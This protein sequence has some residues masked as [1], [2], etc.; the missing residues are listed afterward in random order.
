[1]G[2]VYL[3][4]DNRLN[5]NVALK[6]VHAAA[7]GGP[8]ASRLLKEARAASSLNHPN[9]AQIY[10]VNEA[11]DAG[12]IAME[13][14]D[15]ETLSGR[16]M[17]SPPL[18]PA[19]VINIGIEVAEA[20]EE[21]HNHG[22]IHR[23]IKPANIMITKKGR[24][25][26]LDF[27]VA[28]VDVLSSASTVRD[29]P[30]A[31]TGAVIGTVRYMSPEQARGQQVDSRSDLF[32]LGIVLYELATGRLPF[33][34]VSTFEIL[35]KIVRAD[36]PP[37]RVGLPSLEDI[38]GR[39]LQKQPDRRPDSATTVAAA[40]RACLIESDLRNS[41]AKK[42]AVPP[43]IVRKTTIVV[44]TLVVAALFFWAVR[45]PPPANIPNARQNLVIL[46][47]H[48]LN[49]ESRDQALSDG[50][51]ENVTARII[52][53]ASRQNIDVT[54]AA[55]VKSRHVVKIE[56]AR[57]E[58]GANLAVQGTA[59]KSGT[60]LRISWTLL[61]TSTG[62]TIRSDNF[63][64]DNHDPFLLQDRMLERLAALLNLR[65]SM[66]DFATPPKG[67]IAAVGAY[68]LYLQGRGY[69]QN[70]DKPENLEN[71]ITVFDEA[72]KMDPNYA[73]VHAGL[74][75]TYWRKYETTK[76]VKWM[77]SARGAC[78]HALALD[79]VPAEPHRCLGFVE[80]AVGHYDKA[81]LEFQ[82]AIAREPNDDVA[83]AGMA[84]AYDRMNDAQ[85]AEEAYSKAIR[86]RPNYWG[87]YSQF[88][89]YYFSKAR[90]G[91]AERMFL[92]VISLVPDSYRGYSNLGAMHF[93]QGKI[94]EAI[95]DYSKSMSLKPNYQAA[96]N[97]GT[98]YYYEGDYAKSAS[99][100]E[101][102]LA[103]NGTD[104]RVWGNLGSARHL[105][106]NFDGASRAFKEAIRMGE[107]K[108]QVNPN[109]A[110]LLA[111]LAGYYGPVGQTEKAEMLIRNALRLAPNNGEVLYR[112][113]ALYESDLHQRE[114]ALSFIEKTI[115]V[116]FSRKE[117]DRSPL[118]R[119][120][121]ND[122]RFKLLI[123]QT[124]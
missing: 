20:L 35:E 107:L 7:G 33:E 118:F 76:D 110:V 3:A 72:L 108:L 46:P 41:T 123:Q 55:D 17:H 38:I 109:D 88:G 85:K 51:M 122:P 27:G 11:G 4:W 120:L 39:C 24:I 90:Y 86:M 101:Q 64:L 52:D 119:E 112:A 71:A 5:R 74:G 95:K 114:K 16:M 14:V 115:R 100:V 93:L 113:A 87:G 25:K 40:L 89:A 66:D 68:E 58:L 37:M 45:R 54:A 22:V 111:Q 26:V 99:N 30:T 91:E 73:L 97:L 82:H 36:P 78:E 84:S 94:P 19:E 106:Q 43:E 13:Y 18:T 79:E 62:Q 8:Q 29:A 103:I 98:L 10:E 48:F 83:Y 121:R 57:T 69:L 116:G 15:G 80:N 23:D 61:N 34:G 12:Y 104:Y 56:D 47:L 96:S 53:V 21:A 2:D 31:A 102:A 105:M 117:I 49:E 77:D 70:Y 92:Q 32:S 65:T 1:M 63:T 60:F 6:V 67:H 28:K 44:V 124:P 42:L 75:E 59:E 50:L 81:V 9:V